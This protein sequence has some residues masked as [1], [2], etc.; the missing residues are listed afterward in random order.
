MK[1]AKSE[2]LLVAGLLALQ[3]EL[4]KRI[5]SLMNDTGI[6]LSDLTLHDLSVAGLI[7]VRAQNGLETEG[8]SGDTTLAGLSKM[9]KAR[10]R[11]IRSF[12]KKCRQELNDVFAAVGIG[13]RY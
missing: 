5:R 11:Q 8:I 7:S 3:I 6:A 10:V 4:G 1:K 13:T 9:D 2:A 12:G